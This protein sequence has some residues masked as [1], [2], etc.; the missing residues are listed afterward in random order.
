MQKKFK[1]Y[2]LVPIIIALI[3]GTVPVTA[4]LNNNTFNF[5]IYNQQGNNISNIQVFVDGSYVTV[6]N[7]IEYI[8]LITG[9]PGYSVFHFIQNVNGEF[10]WMGSGNITM[11][12]PLNVS[13]LNNVTI[14][15]F[16]LFYRVLEGKN[17]TGLIISGIPTVSSE[18]TIYLNSIT[19]TFL[20]FMVVPIYAPISQIIEENGTY[21]GN[22]ISFQ[23]E[24]NTLE[25][26]GFRFNNVTIQPIYKLILNGEGDY[27]NGLISS[28]GQLIS[29]NDNAN[30]EIDL[31]N[32]YGNI[33][34]V[35]NPGFNFTPSN[36]T[37]RTNS[38]FE[39]P[40]QGILDHYIIRYRYY[41]I[42]LNN[43][44]IG[45]IYVPGDSRILSNSSILINDP[46]S[47]VRI[48]LMNFELSAANEI[49]NNL[50][51]NDS[52]LGV[53]YLGRN[54]SYIPING[55]YALSYKINGNEAY[56]NFVSGQVGSVIIAEKRYLK[57]QEVNVNG[58]NQSFQLIGEANGTNFYEVP[59]NYEGPVNVSVHYVNV[60]QQKIKSLFNYFLIGG[61]VLIIASVST[62]MI[63][64][65]KHRNAA[66]KIIMN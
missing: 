2:L 51:S 19:P 46:F 24:G 15:G 12:T 49:F 40:F 5:I 47:N 38:I 4:H 39:I 54:L 17:V 21:I 52:Y 13:D 42:K 28:N 59:V 60:V 11:V 48:I 50:L 31:F 32:F 16:N 58:E 66:K 57:I 41:D 30:P 10:Y 53:F 9:M 34:I 25:N 1:I 3:I 43:S 35:L 44:V 64:Y 27:E 37:Q 18:N 8:Q 7:Y 55:S 45:Y 61:I 20:M 65:I 22:F 26:I 6:F 56:V 23:M 14:L 36:V 63:A 33:E 29:I 62:I